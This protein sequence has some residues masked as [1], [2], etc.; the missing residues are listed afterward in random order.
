[1]SAS[2]RLLEALSTSVAENSGLSHSGSITMPNTIP[3]SARQQAPALQMRK[4]PSQA[5]GDST[6]SGANGVVWSPHT[7]QDDS[8][9]VSDGNMTLMGSVR[10]IK[11][12]E[13]V[14]SMRSPRGG[15]SPRASPQQY[16]FSATGSSS[17]RL[18]LSATPDASAKS[19]SQGT[20]S[21]PLGPARS[22]SGA[23]VAPEL[24]RAPAQ[25]A[26]GGIAHPVPQSPLPQERI[27]TAR[28]A[29]TNLPMAHVMSMGRVAS[30]SASTIAA[31]PARWQSSQMSPRV[32]PPAGST[33][34]GSCVR[35][36][37]PPCQKLSG[38]NVAPAPL[39]KPANA[40]PTAPIMAT[41]SSTTNLTA[42]V[43]ISGNF[44]SA[45]VTAPPA[46]AW[47]PSIVRS[48]STTGVEQI[49]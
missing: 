18:Q 49:A 29:P 13:S 4:W 32:G 34:A 38:S 11:N 35:M 41:G 16:P 33:S 5:A 47:Q 7:R 9:Q 21:A 27:V 22:S 15:R 23:A 8:R 14:T 48:Q 3:S 31:K 40:Q 37:R 24:R 10:N 19:G 20:L 43:Q 17:P 2:V 45:S 1:L 39:S 6:A 25:T 12:V 42:G 30:P 36:V 26:Q 28:A 46:S 44:A